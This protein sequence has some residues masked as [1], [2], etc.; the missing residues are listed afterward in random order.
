[1]TEKL[2]SSYKLGKLELANRTVMSPMT[3]SRAIGNVPNDLMATYYAQRAEAG[4]I[5]TEGTSP[6][7]NGL[8]YAR[9]PGLFD[10][11]QVEGWKKVT[12]AVHAAGSKIFVQLMHTGR[13]THP[14]NLP[15]GA[16]TL[17]PSAVLLDGH[18]YTDEDGPQ[19]H[20]TPEAMTDAEVESTI[21]EFVLSAKLAIEA[22]FDGVELHGANGYLI[23]Q[24][25]NTASNQRTDRWGGSVE[26][27][28]RFAIEVARRAAAA[29]GADRVGIRL[30][31]YG[32]F[33]GM[34][35][36]AET[37]ALYTHVAAELGKVGLAYIH[38]VDHASMG[39]PAVPP[40][41][42]EAI[43]KSFG[44]TILLS[45]GYDAKRA[46]ADL[47]EGK[48]ELV[49][50]GRPFLANPKLVTKLRSGAELAAPDAS[51]FYTPGEKGYTD[52]PA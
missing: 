7:P 43:R 3:R 33:N 41:I 46:E 47:V 26:N 21:G 31:P 2:F 34:T 48:G 28:A 40:S 25:L 30:S 17:A 27:R 9:I 15:A 11:A 13:V 39:A 42:K 50:F 45:G 19:P 16:R 32:V 12:S 37:D 44:G 38:L 14:K 52:Y 1:V 4:L 51:T 18:M 10:A 22:G 36:D 24:F 49:A 5:V 35:P 23:E 8:G 20:P 29:I 6:S